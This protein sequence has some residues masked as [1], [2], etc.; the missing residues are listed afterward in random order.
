M[1]KDADAVSGGLTWKGFGN[2]SLALAGCP[3]NQRERHFGCATIE[4]PHPI[5]SFPSTSKQMLH[6]FLLSF[7]FDR[8]C[9][10]KSGHAWIG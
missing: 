7:A 1:K 10:T 2:A 3:L 5:R 4:Q 9:D 8:S 6:V